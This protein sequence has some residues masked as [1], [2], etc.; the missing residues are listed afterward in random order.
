MLPISRAITTVMKEAAFPAVKV[1][2]LR[3]VVP[4]THSVGSSPFGSS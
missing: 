1:L 3:D 4:F 2:A